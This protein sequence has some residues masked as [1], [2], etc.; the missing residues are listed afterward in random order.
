MPFDWQAD[1][2]LRMPANSEVEHSA[3][4]QVG[5]GCFS[6]FVNGNVCAAIRFRQSPPWLASFLNDLSKGVFPGLT[7]RDWIAVFGI[8]P[9]TFFATLNV[10]LRTGFVLRPEHKLVRADL[11][12]DSR[13]Q[14]ME[15]GMS[16]GTNTG[17]MGLGR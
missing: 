1:D 10:L 5:G 15:A 9:A 17:W 2:I 6:L 4:E 14:A 13:W 12:R 7:V 16:R 11:G 3:T 8:P